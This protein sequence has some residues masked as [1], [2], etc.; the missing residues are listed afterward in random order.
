MNERELSKIQISELNRAPDGS[1][2]TP[3][4]VSNMT[5]QEI[6]A[7]LLKSNPEA[8]E[9]IDRLEV[10]EVKYL[11]KESKFCVGQI[12]VD[13]DLSAEVDKLFKFLLDQKFLLDKVVPV[14]SEAYD[15]SD[16][17][18]MQDNN[19]SAENY[20]VIEGTDRL[21]L[22]AFG[23][24]IDLNPRDNPIQKDG[25]TIAPEGAVRNPEDSQTFTAEHPVVKWLEERGWEWGG[26]WQEP[27]QDYHHFQKPLATEQYVKQL[28]KQLQEQNISL[29]DF[30][31]RLDKA[32][33]NSENLHNEKI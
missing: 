10:L 24:A 5:R 9:I 17:A 27:Y 13:K 31:T 29:E 11:N 22:H 15:G 26:S 6:E 12:V 25:V 20:R 7:A 23:F 2:E 16:I 21:S 30:T 14:Q 4:V 3:L 8:K 28:E 1:F 33:M 19:S 18:S 32:K